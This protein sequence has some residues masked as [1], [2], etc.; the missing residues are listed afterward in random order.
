MS[1]VFISYAR[2]TASQANAAA[3]ALRAE[4]YSVWMDEDLPAHRPYAREI[5]TELAVAK[6]ALVI[7]SGE[8]VESEWVLSEAN[9]ARED[10][11]LVQVRV[12][13][14]RL[15]MPFD[16]IQ[17][18]DLT[19]W[20]GRGDHPGW[21]KVADSVL[22]LVGRG[23]AVAAKPVEQQIHFC[24]ASD[25]VRI[26]YA[27]AGGGPPLLKMANWLGHLEQDWESP[28]WGELFR[29]ISLQHTLIRYDQRAAGLSDWV[30]D[31]LSLEGYIRDVEAVI[32][33]TGLE[34]FPIMAI[35]QGGGVAIEYAARHPDRVSRLILLNAYANGW[36]TWEPSLVAT[37][38]GIKLMI[39][40]AWGRE[41]PAFR[42]VFT[43]LMMPGGSPQ[44]WDAFDAMQ[45]AS[46]SPENAARLFESFGQID[47]RARLGEVRA[48]TLVLHSRNDQLV[49]VTHGQ[50]IAAGIKGAKFVSLPT[51]NHIVLKT[52]PAFTRL[53]DEVLAF[54]AADA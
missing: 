14:A 50:E 29:R 36:R 11:K 8:A 44:Q 51:N 12:D 5:E 40:N 52:E 1:D 46:T 42:A 25:G 27:T 35:S 33:A 6:A 26:A 39:A 30:T 22:A 21:R 13:G 31:E 49:A 9:R 24:V 10:R 41:S 34:R 32:E 20:S 2:S 38:E 28:V 37:A 3:E 47:V 45:R 54:L 18:A 19:S 15:P 4:G 7:W 53:T 23:V 16:Q 43:G 48:P 17:C